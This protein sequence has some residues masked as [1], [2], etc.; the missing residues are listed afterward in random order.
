MTSLITA[1]AVLTALGCLLGG[2]ELRRL[3]RLFKEA[4]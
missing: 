2:P 3:W 4:S 1:A